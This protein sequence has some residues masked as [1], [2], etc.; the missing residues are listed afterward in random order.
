[1]TWD[2]DNGT[3]DQVRRV[4]SA[5]HPVVFVE[6]WEEERLD[7]ILSSLMSDG[8]GWPVWTWS[9]SRGFH[10]GPGS[11]QDFEDIS[12]ALAFARDAGQSAIWL[13][14]DLPSYVDRLGVKRALR[15][16][17][18]AFSCGSGLVVGCAPVFEISND[19]RK[20]IHY[21]RLSPPDRKEIES[22]LSQLN[23]QLSQDDRFTADWLANCAAE[24]KGFTINECRDLFRNLATS[25]TRDIDPAKDRI[26]E[27]RAQALMKESC[28]EVINSDLDLDSLGG[29]ANLKKW[30]ISRRLLF[31]LEAQQE[32]IAPPSGVLMMG[33]SGCGKSMSAKVIAS[34]WKLPLVRLDMNLIMSG[35]ASGSPELAWSRALI[36]IEAIAPV[37]VWLD[38]IEDSFGVINGQVGSGNLTIFSSFLTWMQ[39]KSKGVFVVATANNIELLPAEMLRKGRFDELFFL[40]LPKKGAREQILAIHIRKQGGDPSAFDLSQL[41]DF[42]EGWTAAELEQLVRAAHLQAFYERRPFVYSDLKDISFRMVPLSKTMSE[43]INELRRWSRSR[44]VPAD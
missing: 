17:Y 18:D 4:L 34:M 6:T 9:S 5:G 40:D 30:I 14:R 24:M 21:L 37:V 19:L 2:I 28:L 25:K 12:S 33:V 41:A 43:Q 42:V 3:L 26:R 31:G 11:A 38:E 35:G 10:N 23:D 20:E 7:Y 1:M 16:L 8:L 13:F 39:E 22:F 36:N 44:A 32:G 15:D 29:L 27:Q